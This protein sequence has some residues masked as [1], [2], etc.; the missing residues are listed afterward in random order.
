MYTFL[1]ATFLPA[2]DAALSVNDLSI[3]R[4]YGIFDFFKTIAG[5]PIFLEDHL[6]RFYHSAARMRLDVGKTRAALKTIIAELQQLNH[7]PDSGIRITLTG[8]IS[9]D[10]ISLGRPNLIITQHPMTPPGIDCPPPVRLISYSHQRQLPDVKTIDYLMA[11]HLQP[12]I[13]ERG[14]F[15]VLYHNNGVITECP[16]CNFF[17]VTA[18]GT[19]ATPSRNMLKGITRKKVLEFA[20]ANSKV[21]ERDVRLAE[22]PTAREAF[23]TST[24]RHLIPISHVDDFP[25]GI[26]ASPTTVNPTAASPNAPTPTTANPQAPTTPTPVPTP[27]PGPLTR[28]LNSLLYDLVNSKK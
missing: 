2:A 21:E 23:I 15:D 12:V 5:Q 14:A 3:Q 26:A 16:R 9:T 8:G 1:N 20:H 19:L 24:S 6:D 18:D 25:I 22:I 13:R 28:K 11:I 10:S 27:A 17:I 7:V 4:G